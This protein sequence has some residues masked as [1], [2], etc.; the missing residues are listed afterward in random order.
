ER[1]RLAKS[2]GPKAKSQAPPKRQDRSPPLRVRHVQAASS[3]EGV[4]PC[5]KYMRARG[6]QGS[7]LSALILTSKDA[8]T[9]M[10]TSLHLSRRREAITASSYGQ[11]GNKTEQTQHNQCG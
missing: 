11:C 1:F 3:R 8:S 5:R 10:M 7:R 6:S 9:S 4:C 2:H